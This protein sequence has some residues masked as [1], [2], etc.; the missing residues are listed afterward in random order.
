MKKTLLLL[1]ISSAV[2]NCSNVEEFE[3]VS[4]RQYADNVI[5]FSSEWSPSPG[6]WSA[7]RALGKENVYDESK[8]QNGYGDNTNA[9]SSATA[10]DQREY[11]VLGFDTLQTVHTIEIYETYFPGA[12][13]TVYVRNASTQQ[14]EKVYAKP[15]ITDLPEVARIFSI[16]FRETTYLVDAIRIA[17]NSPAVTDQLDENGN[18]IFGW[19]EIDAVAI[20][21]QREN[22]P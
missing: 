21:G 4:I 19:N 9:W 8:P 18:E 20:G 12:I 5:D 7:A 14:W 17:I 1:F 13:D 22:N 15:A 10:D 11:L 3:G 16:Y 6:V 2:F